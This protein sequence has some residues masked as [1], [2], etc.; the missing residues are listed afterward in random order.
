MTGPQIMPGA[1]AGGAPAAGSL[2][3]VISQALDA[4][5]RALRGHTDA[6]NM[7]GNFLPNDGT[8][9]TRSYNT[10]ETGRSFGEAMGQFGDP[11]LRALNMPFSMNPFSVQTA[12]TSVQLNEQYRQSTLS[13]AA[14]QGIDLS[15]S[16]AIEKFRKDL[17]SVQKEFES[18]GV[19]LTQA[20]TKIQQFSAASFATGDR[21]TQQTLAVMQA[22][23][24]MGMN[25]GNPGFA[26]TVMQGGNVLEG[27][28]FVRDN[29]AL[30][31]TG[32]AKDMLTNLAGGFVERDAQLGI[33]GAGASA[34]RFQSSI[35]AFAKI[36]DP[37]NPQA[38][39]QSGAAMMGNLQSAFKSPA[40]AGFAM[41]AFG[42]QDFLGAMAM[43][44]D[45]K[46]LP[47]MLRRLGRGRGM[48]TE[49]ARTGVIS[50]TQ[51]LKY[52]EAS[53]AEMETYYAEMGKETEP[54]TV[55]PFLARAAPAGVTEAEQAGATVTN[56]LGT[57]R[58]AGFLNTATSKVAGFYA[59]IPGPVIATSAVGGLGLAGFG[60][61][62]S[63]L[64]RR[65]IDANAPRTRS[66]MR[67]ML[68]GRL[69]PGLTG[70]G[71]P[72]TRGMAAKL[73]LGRILGGV[74]SR[75][76]AT[77]QSLLM[78]L[79]KG[80]RAALRG[81]LTKRSLAG[82]AV[83]VVS[84]FA[85]GIIDAV[86][87]GGE[88]ANRL[89]NAF[90]AMNTG[91]TYGAG[92]GAVAGGIAGAGIFSLPGA[93]AGS[94]TGGLI[95]GAL[96]F[97]KGYFS[98]P[99]RPQQDA[100]G[101]G[102]EAS[103]GGVLST[104]QGIYRVLVE[105]LGAGSGGVPGGGGSSATMLMPVDG[106]DEG[107]N[108]FPS[109]GSN[110]LNPS[111]YTTTS[112]S[113]SALTPA[114]KALLN[115]YLAQGKLPQG[116][117]AVVTSVLR[118]AAD[119]AR[120]AGASNSKHLTGEAVDFQLMDAQGRP[121]AAAM[122]EYVRMNQGAMNKQGIDVLSHS[123]NGGGMHIHMEVDKHQK[124]ALKPLS[125]VTSFEREMLRQSTITAQGM[126]LL[127]TNT[128]AQTGVRSRVV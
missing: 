102:T 81:L 25:P 96:G 62:R 10:F 93:I 12:A 31:S 45:T 127:S 42:G 112:N 55:N 30:L 41:S 20:A 22:A 104:L 61:Y 88:Q 27:L 91:A 33:S 92:I 72:R 53:D 48:L 65:M 17:G 7:Q 56:A 34:D 78:G 109:G 69:F 101:A 51:A 83:G 94:G 111:M 11:Y 97:A 2:P 46:N 67:R 3:D 52:A 14:A 98:D 40:L 43:A 116:S 85:P 128:M 118:S 16:G 114:A 32:A 59:N 9:G 90:A 57:S 13:G 8:R 100:P 105:R 54:T 126:S 6:L 64:M 73:S 58:F 95:G 120:V 121:D 24:A 117:R 70:G 119:N 115:P 103:D 108:P 29:Q 37:N 84:A 60:F 66:L 38:M 5:A 87:G 77:R 75:R 86:G 71:V 125:G 89:A 74:A 79:A 44:E 35:L 49:L 23:S 107:S 113:L 36:L 124:E 47:T 110:P 99:T 26:S 76:A 80:G 106:Q 82:A 1:G 15:Q 122:E 4:H 21:A 123:V 18:L 50:Y 63:R 28:Q 39:L 68:A 19:T